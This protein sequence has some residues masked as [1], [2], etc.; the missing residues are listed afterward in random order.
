MAKVDPR[1][2]C[3]SAGGMAGIQSLK[4]SE[5][6]LGTSPLETTA[7]LA[8]CRLDDLQ[9]AVE[10]MYLGCDIED[11]GV[12]LVVASEFSRQAPVVCATS[13]V[14]GLVV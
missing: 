3:G 2:M 9:L 7:A 14:H 13:Q 6:M 5:A 8:T 12:S 10:H 4:G 1:G 11:A